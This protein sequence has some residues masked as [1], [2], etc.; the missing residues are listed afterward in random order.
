[1]S[2][3]KSSGKKQIA[4]T[5]LRKDRGEEDVDEGS[6]RPNCQV[7]SCAR[8]IAPEHTLGISAHVGEALFGGF[9]QDRSMLDHCMNRKGSL[10]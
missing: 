9:S 8:H 5:S 3:N 10:D 2:I 6:S 1:M 4:I 7:L